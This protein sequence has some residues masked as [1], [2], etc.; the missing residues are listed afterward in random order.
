MYKRGD[1][2]VSDFWHHGKR[3]K[4]SWKNVSKTIAKE[5][6]RKFKTEIAEGKHNL[7]ARRILF[8]TFA[9]NYMEHAK[10]HKKPSS[11][12]RNQTSIH[13]LM[14][15]FKGKLLESIDPFMVEQ[16]K[17]ARRE[18]G[19]TPAT[20]NRDTATLRN[21]LNKAV[22]WGYLQIN[23]M[24]GVKQF[25]E[26]NEQMWV[27]TPKE[28]DRLLDGAEQAGGKSPHLK[29]IMN[30]A[31]HTGMRLSE[32]L[33]MEKRHV[34]LRDRYIF[35]P[36]SIAKNHKSRKVPINDTLAQILRDAFK[37]NHSEYVFPNRQGEAHKDIKNG[38]W[39]AVE[40][41]G[42]VRTEK[43]N[44]KL[45]K[46]RFRFHDLR[47]TFGSRLGMKGV[48]TKTI[49]EI[50]GHRTEKMAMRYQHPTPKHKLEAV[51]LLDSSP[52]KIHTRGEMAEKEK[53]VSIR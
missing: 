6:E 34:H 2:W 13:M 16:Y 31:L 44:G 8:E 45:K 29:A 48:D 3:Y 20:V 10:L 46:V 18:E 4:K 21:M 12:K 42:L 41:A 39:T 24:N 22:E 47:H 35:V 36:E 40:R 38:V 11:A 5:K 51:K 32:V 26:D 1:S 49:M 17:K 53:V 14:P 19:K 43:R 50:M 25:N 33:E 37:G 7:K 27:L 52:T 9:E 30:T 23:P 28:E 15:H